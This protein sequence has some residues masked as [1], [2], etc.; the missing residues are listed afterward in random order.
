[1]Q[2]IKSTSFNIYPLMVTLGLIVLSVIARVWAPK[3]RAGY[4]NKPSQWKGKVLLVLVL[5]LLLCCCHLPLP[6]VFAPPPPHTL[7]PSTPSIRLC[8]SVTPPQPA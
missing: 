5:L 4:G 6:V 1:M 8:M 3:D 2:C 7:P